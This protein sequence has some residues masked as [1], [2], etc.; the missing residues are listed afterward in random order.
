M[1]VPRS[2]AKNK[3]HPLLG[4]GRTLSE[5]W[6]RQI[7]EENSRSMSPRKMISPEAIDCSVANAQ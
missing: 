3:E 1:Q 5:A 2:H 7:L 4:R 6:K